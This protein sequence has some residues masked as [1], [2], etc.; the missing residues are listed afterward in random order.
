[1]KIFKLEEEEHMLLFTMSHI[2]SDAWSVEKLVKEVRGLYDA[3]SKGQGSPLQE[4]DIQYADYAC[5]QRQ[6]LTGD[7]LEKSLDYWKRQLAGKL[8]T[9]DLPL[10]HPRPPV[11]RYRG[12]VKSF[13]VPGELA[14]SLR[15]LSKRE[16]VTLSMVL[17]AA[18]KT[19]LYRYTEQ[20]DI[21]VGTATA[22]RIP[23]EVRPLIGPFV[24]M[25][26]LRTNLGGNPRFREL[27]RRVKDVT[28]GRY[29]YQDLP[30]EKLIEKIKPESAAEELSL[31]NVA[32]G[33]QNARQEDLSINGI[34]IKPLAAEKEM[35]RFDLGL[36]VTEGP[37]GMH[38]CWTYRND[39]FEEATIIRTHNHFETLLF[40]IIDRPNDRI[41]SIK[42]SS[43]VKSGLNDK[44][45]TDLE[46][47]NRRRL[48]TVK[49]KGVNLTTDHA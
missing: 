42:V 5:W 6:Y 33:L 12:E 24:N 4:L 39:L 27:L 2:V 29:L 8:P 46:N 47:S 34:E 38:V 15:E 14:Q 30:F 19:L 36:W 44:E 35:A 9:L 22:D 25:L 20:E 13:S 11:F 43:R 37:E 45:Q 40:N 48:R 31:F 17:L 7:V 26:P 10:D 28:L 23:A 41:L 21:I 16:G 1:V 18:F 49:R 3:I 32:F